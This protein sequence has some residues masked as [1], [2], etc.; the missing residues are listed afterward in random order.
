MFEKI[1][2]LKLIKKPVLC[3][4]QLSSITTSKTVENNQQSLWAFWGT[5]TC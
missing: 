2:K 1:S 3:L 5:L 4:P